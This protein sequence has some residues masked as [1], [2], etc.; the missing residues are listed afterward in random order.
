MSGAETRQYWVDE[1]SHN[2][3]LEGMKVSDEYI[4]VAQKYVDGDI[5]ADELVESIRIHYGLDSQ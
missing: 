5:S 1:A 4:A 2:I 3:E